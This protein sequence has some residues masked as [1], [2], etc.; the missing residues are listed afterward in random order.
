MSLC[1]VYLKSFYLIMSVNTKLS[2]YAR[3]QWEHGVLESFNI[4]L[5]RAVTSDFSGCFRPDVP[6]SGAENALQTADT[7][8]VVRG[9][10]SKVIFYTASVGMF[11]GSFYW[12]F[13]PDCCCC[14]RSN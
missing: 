9:G 10:K 2:I 5:C 13:K 3:S 14:V 4:T 12:H 1:D 11:K 6:F 8:P 7:V